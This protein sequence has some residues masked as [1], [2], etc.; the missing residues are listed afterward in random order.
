MPYV[1]TK[2]ESYVHLDWFGTITT[3]DL[4]SIGK[5]LTKVMAERGFAPH[6]LHT[7]D[8]IDGMDFGPWAMFMH[9]LLR[10]DTL[11]PNKSKSAQVAKSEKARSVC[12]M[13][14]DLNR[15]PD[16]EMQLFGDEPSAI[17][18]LQD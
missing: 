1:L 17:A 10:E 2:K 6:V 7:F 13:F 18:W 9:S 5:D 12:K 8:Q 11:L 16:I 3:N 15:N 4:K 14:R